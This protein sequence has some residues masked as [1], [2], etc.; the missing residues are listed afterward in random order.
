MASRWLANSY[1][2]TEIKDMQ[3]NKG[4]YETDNWDLVDWFEYD[5]Y[6][7]ANSHYDILE[8]YKKKRSMHT[9]RDTYLVQGLRDD[10]YHPNNKIGPS[11]INNM[12]L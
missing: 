10:K 1:P 12:G 7:E 2:L 3:L 6:E 11:P 9:S 8:G 4:T 5:N